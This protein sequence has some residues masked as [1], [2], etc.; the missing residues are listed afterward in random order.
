[1]SNEDTDQYRDFIAK[2]QR[3]DQRPAA[4]KDIKNLFVY[5]PPGEAANAIRD[6]GI[7]KIVHCLN[8]PDKYVLLNLRSLDS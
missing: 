5:K 1:M 2:L 6:V 3:E 7:S 4:L 8:A